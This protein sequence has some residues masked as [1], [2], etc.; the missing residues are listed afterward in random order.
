MQFKMM[1]PGSVQF[2]HRVTINTELL[3]KTRTRANLFMWLAKNIEPD[4]NGF[5]PY[6]YTEYKFFFKRSKDATA[7]ALKW[8]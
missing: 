8:A 4:N 5:R 7:F 1:Q 3:R 2:E 6:T